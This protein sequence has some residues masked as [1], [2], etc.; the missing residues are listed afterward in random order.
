[1]RFLANYI[2]QV[3]CNHLY[4]VEEVYATHYDDDGRIIQQGDRVYM[5]CKKCGYYS[6]H[7]KH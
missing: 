2:R 6:K 5:R 1:M 7:W 4:E 3:F